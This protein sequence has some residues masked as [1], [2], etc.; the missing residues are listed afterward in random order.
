M[1]LVIL[2]YAKFFNAIIASVSL[3]YGQ[4]AY[5]SCNVDDTK[6]GNVLENIEEANDKELQAISYFLLVISALL[7]AFGIIVTSCVFFWQWL[8]QYQDKAIFKWAR[9][10]VSETSPLARALPCSLY[11]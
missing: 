11:C 2:S 3:L 9:P 6:L 4:P 7:F 5:G 1:I 10:E 8:L